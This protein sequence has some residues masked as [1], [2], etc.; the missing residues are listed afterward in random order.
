M[1]LGWRRRS[2]HE[3]TLLFIEYDVTAEGVIE[4]VALINATEQSGDDADG[5][6]W[7][8]WRVAT[9]DDDGLG[10]VA[11]PADRLISDGGDGRR[12]SAPRHRRRHR[13]RRP[14]GEGTAATV[15]TTR[16]QLYRIARDLGNVEA[17]EHGYTHGGLSAPPVAP[18]SGRHAGSSTGRATARSTGSLR[19]IGL[20][21]RRR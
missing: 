13:S 6:A 17:V 1:P 10:C 4:L 3:E 20:G 18:P 15:S 9:F 2:D 8:A 7:M 19:T 5:A 21:P 12:R 14:C 11:V 16:S